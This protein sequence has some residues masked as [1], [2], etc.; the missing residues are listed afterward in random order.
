MMLYWF[1]PYI[2]MNQ[3]YIYICP[4]TLE[5]PFHLPVHPMALHCQPRLSSLHHT[6]NSHWLAILH[7]VM[8][9]FQCY[10]L[11]LPHPL[12]PILCPQV[13]SLHL[14]L[15]CCPTKQVHQYKFSRFHTCALI[16]DTCFSLSLTSFCV[17]GSRFTY[18]FRT[19]SNAFPFMVE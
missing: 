5:P 9:R 18:L 8:Y 3:P 13:C 2:N 7:M 19:G 16:Y 11:S 12:L 6:A 1:L 4:I 14:S 15:Y 17:I 10:S